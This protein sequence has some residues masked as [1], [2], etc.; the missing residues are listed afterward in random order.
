MTRIFGWTALVL[1]IIGLGAT[2]AAA[3]LERA[4]TVRSA[5]ILAA[6]VLALEGMVWLAIS[7]T[8]G[9][10]TLVTF[11]VGGLLSFI[12]VAE[13]TA[14]TEALLF[15]TLASVAVVGYAL[16]LLGLLVRVV[17][18]QITRG[19]FTA[20]ARTLRHTPSPY[21]ESSPYRQPQTPRIV[22]QDP[23]PQH[24]YTATGTPSRTSWAASSD[25]WQRSDA[26]QFFATRQQIE[27]QR[28]QQSGARR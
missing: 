18:R 11:V 1:L 9:F 3:P 12:L 7:Q 16:T 4:Q 17:D 21:L 15:Q 5:I 27:S 20:D 23:L 8:L 10:A 14:A 13:P 24:P 26:G 6:L 2:Y 22:R 28:A 19:G 25:A